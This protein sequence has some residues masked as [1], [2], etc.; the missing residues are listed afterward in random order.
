MD[1]QTKLS[2]EQI[3]S[4]KNEMKNVDINEKT[5]TE[6]FIKKH[7]NEEQANKVRGILNDPEKLQ[8]VLSSPMAQRFLASL[9]SRGGKEE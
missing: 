4:I 9:K 6:E 3:N 5:D 7:L 2:E 8:S 1:K